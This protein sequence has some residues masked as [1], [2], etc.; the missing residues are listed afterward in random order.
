MPDRIAHIGF[1]KTATTF[2]QKSVFPFIKGI[3]YVDYRSCEALFF[4]L[5]LLDELDFDHGSAS[6]LIEN[7]CTQD[8]TTLFSFEGLC[9]VP[10]IY[11]GLGKS[12]VPGRLKE[13]GFNK[14]I[15][16]LRNQETQID[17]LYRQ[18]VIQ[19]GVVRFGYFLNSQ[20]KLGLNRR[21]FNLEYLNYYKLIKLYQK[22]FGVDNV[23]ILSHRELVEDQRSFMEK[24]IG[25][26]DPESGEISM[27]TD[28]KNTSLSNLSINILRRVNHFIFTSQKPNNLVWNKISTKYVSKIFKV[29]LD[30]YL[31][32]F[33]SSKKSYVNK[34]NRLFLKDYYQSSNQK[35]RDLLGD[36]FEL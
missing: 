14:I 2:L 36:E 25:F 24:I 19:G 21:V 32:K 17:S 18:Y 12:S 27:K 10:F 30:P 11:N 33:L 28:K 8:K 22:T 3:N 6:K 13:L 29:I 15:V 1:P 31:F 35:L 16:T 26:V 9:G 7:E 34:K 4:P 20:G 23:M 5:I